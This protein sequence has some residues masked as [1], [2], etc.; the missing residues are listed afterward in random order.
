MLLVTALVLSSPDVFLPVDGVRDDVH[1]APVGFCARAA[2]LE[3]QPLR[4]P[5]VCKN[6]FE[7]A[8]NAERDAFAPGGIWA[9]HASRP[10]DAA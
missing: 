4:P 3:G 9:S 10:A 6:L 7:Y 2:G 5:R 8:R 1:V